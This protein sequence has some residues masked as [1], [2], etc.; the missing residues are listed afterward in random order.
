MRSITQG[1]DLSTVV[2]ALDERMV[3]GHGRS[4]DVDDGR[5]EHCDQDVHFRCSFLLTQ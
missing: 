3:L 5:E 4:L 2:H 1:E